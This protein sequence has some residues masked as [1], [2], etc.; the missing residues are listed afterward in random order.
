MSTE[1]FPDV[2]GACFCG[3]VAYRC[4]GNPIWNANCHCS[5]CQRTTG[6]AFT[7]ELGYQKDQVT[8]TKGE[9][10]IV[11][12]QSTEKSKR[13]RCSKCGSQ[14]GGIGDVGFGEVCW[15]YVGTL[16]RDENNVVKWKEA[17]VPDMHVFYDTRLTDVLDG[18]PKWTAIPGESQLLSDTGMPL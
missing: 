18:K 12:L 2:T 9:D 6:C 1:P 14:L 13:I 15:L 4:T 7:P 10:N 17:R 8:F 11:G 16:D 3:A 5:F